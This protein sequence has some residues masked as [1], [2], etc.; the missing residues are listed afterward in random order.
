MCLFEEGAR[1]V[2]GVG[3][4]AA[5]FAAPGDL[6][7][8]SA[9]TRFGP[10]DLTFT[11]TGTA[12]TLTLTAPTPPPGGYDL[13]LPFPVARV[14][15]DDSLLADWRVPSNAYD[16]AGRSALRLPPSARQVQ[17]FRSS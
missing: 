10:L 9:S 12:A 3:W 15:V 16:L 7:I 1:L 2:L 4:P 11:W 17:V 5:W 6:A 14:L 13:W 8:E